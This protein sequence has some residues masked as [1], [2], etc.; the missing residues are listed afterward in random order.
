MDG[1]V[2]A[3]VFRYLLLMNEFIC[4]FIWVHMQDFTTFLAIVYPFLTVRIMM[5][6]VFQMFI[7]IESQ[8]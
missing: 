4:S 8:F 3:A 1:T 6:F 5:S 2:D 7:E